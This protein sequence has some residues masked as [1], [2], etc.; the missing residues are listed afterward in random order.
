MQCFMELAGCNDDTENQLA[1]VMLPLE[2]LSIVL[3]EWF[4]EVKKQE[5]SAKVCSGFHQLVIRGLLLIY[6]E[7][8]M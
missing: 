4:M 1:T 7:Y 6:Q 8:V 2:S 3:K 5:R